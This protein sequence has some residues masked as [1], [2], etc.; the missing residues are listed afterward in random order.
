MT[1][2]DRAVRRAERKQAKDFGHSVARGPSLLSRLEQSLLVH[3][4]RYLEMKHIPFGE[5]PSARVDTERGIIRGLAMAVAVI[6]APYE[7]QSRTT[8]RIEKE[9]IQLAR[10]SS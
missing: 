2:H 4:Q 6:R 8:K 7:D 3:C 10:E 1:P 5:E 9:F